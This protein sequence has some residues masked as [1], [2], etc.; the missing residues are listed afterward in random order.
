ME[1]ENIPP[2][3]DDY[4]HKLIE[5][6]TLQEDRFLKIPLD[7]L[8]IIAD[9]LPRQIAFLSTCRLLH[10]IPCTR[11]LVL[12]VPFD[13]TRMNTWWDI[14]RGKNPFK[15][16]AC[17]RELCVFQ[18]DQIGIAYNKEGLLV[19]QTKFA[20]KFVILMRALFPGYH[21]W[22]ISEDQ[23]ELK[24]E[25]KYSLCSWSDDTRIITGFHRT[26]FLNIRRCRLFFKLYAEE[27]NRDPGKPLGYKSFDRFLNYDET[28]PLSLPWYKGANQIL[29]LF[30]G[31]LARGSYV[32]LRSSDIDDNFRLF[33]K[34]LSE[35]PDVWPIAFYIQDHIC[36]VSEIVKEKY[37]FFSP[38]GLIITDSEEAVKSNLD[39]L[40][41]IITAWK[42][43]LGEDTF[44][45]LGYVAKQINELEKYHHEYGRSRADTLAPYMKVLAKIM[46]K[47]DLKI[48][49]D[50]LFKRLLALY[51]PQVCA[52][53]KEWINSQT[54]LD[55]RGYCTTTEDELMRMISCINDN[56]Y[57]LSDKE[58]DEFVSYMKERRVLQRNDLMCWHWAMQSLFE[59]FQASRAKH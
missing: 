48:Q 33:L 12:T 38:W 29:D 57:G 47:A 24:E 40:S 1:E 58:F 11:E 25:L 51:T 10:K 54:Q 32:S 36:K 30:E 31:Y 2:V 46:S 35:H 41:D 26:H 5:E 42:K 27:K 50:R 22:R 15:W 17:V 7:V 13:F 45:I 21:T 28:H 43:C 4:D 23:L 16:N 55:I 34:C 37:H 44:K 56:L 52:T 6:T 53:K 39:R 9:K 8:K 3:I 20:E 59:R 19:R 49:A 14:E 18:I